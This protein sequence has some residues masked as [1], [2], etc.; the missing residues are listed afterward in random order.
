M[1]KPENI[2]G[3]LE[4]ITRH[5][6]EVIKNCFRAGMSFDGLADLFAVIADMLDA[7]AV[8]LRHIHSVSPSSRFHGTFPRSASAHAVPAR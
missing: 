7:L 2:K 1:I 4:T 5:R 3:H 8:R 6:H